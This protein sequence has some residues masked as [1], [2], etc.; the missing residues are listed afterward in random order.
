MY[1][2]ALAREWTVADLQ[3]FPDDGN[4][5]EVIDGELFVTPAPTFTHQEAVMV[6]QRL[7]A[8]YLEREVVAHAVCAPADV[9]FSLKRGVQ[10]D[11]FV[12]PLAAGRRPRHFSDVGRLLLA[13]EVLSPSTARA[14]RVTKRALFRAEGVDEYWIV[15]LDARTIERST[16][17]D[18]RVEVLADT[19]SWLP[20]GASAPLTIDLSNYFQ[21]VLDD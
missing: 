16:P 20:R 12:V 13:V 8:D 17:F 21:R 11:L 19:I 6:L 9:V 14:D 5:Y 3:D 15:D 7:I 4:R 1:M 10:P 18:D 2:P